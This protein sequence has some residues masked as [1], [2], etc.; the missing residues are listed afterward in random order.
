M[1][2]DDYGDSFAVTVTRTDAAWQVRSFNDDFSGLDTSVRAVRALR[3][4][5]P[6]FALLC[7]DDDYFVIVRPTPHGVRILLSDATAAVDDDFAASA[8]DEINADIPDLDPDELDEVDPWA[9]GDFDI[10]ADLGLPEEIMGVICD[11]DE[12]W[13]TDQLIR[14]AEELDFLEELADAADLDLD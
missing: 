1:N 5:G 14:I 12:L 2:A 7:V 11:D 13:P 6:A 3:S 4:E 10:F 8:M 9:E